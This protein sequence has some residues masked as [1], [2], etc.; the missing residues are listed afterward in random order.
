MTFVIPAGGV[1]SWVAPPGADEF[2]KVASAIRGASGGDGWSGD[3]LSCLS[4]DVWN[5]FRSKVSDRWL[6]SGRLPEPLL[7]ARTVY[8]VEEHKLKG[9]R[10]LADHAR[11]LMVLRAFWRGFF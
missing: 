10:L 11:P 6:Q 1:H 3:E 7:H 5:F 9:S 2:R 4:A 8:L